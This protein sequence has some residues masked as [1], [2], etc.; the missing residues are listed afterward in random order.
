MSHRIFE[1]ALIAWAILL[2]P[3]QARAAPRQ[4]HVQMSSGELIELQ[5]P[6]A[7][8]FVAD[9]A[10]ADVQVPSG[11][12]VI[13]FGK[14]PGT[15]T[16]FALDAEGKQLAKTQII[17]SYE[18]GE[19]QNIVRQEVPNGTVNIASTPRGMVL[20]GVVP[21]A[22]AAERARAAAARYI[23][24]KEGLVNQLQISGPQ[25]VNLRVRVAE[26]SR[27]ITKQLG[28]N[29]QAVVSPGAFSFGLATGRNAFRAGGAQ[30][31][32]TDFDIDNVITRATP[33]TQGAA[34][35]GSFFGN[36]QT[37]RATVN[38]VIDALAE[39]GLITILAE[40]NLTAISGQTAS[41]LAGGEFPIPVAQSGAGNTTTITIE[42]KQFGVSLDFVPTVLSSDRISM[43]VRPE[44]SQLSTQ[45][46]IT[47]SSITIPALSVRRAETTVELGSGDSFA[48]AGLIQNT[49]T[50][51]L[52]KYP[53]L[54][55]VPIL[56]SLFRS[57]NFQ[58]NE[59]EL[60]IIVTPYVVRPAS[61]QSML[62]PTD[63]LAPA[64]D[65]E[66]I[67]LGRLNRVSGGTGTVNAIGVNGVR[68][69]GDAGFIE[70]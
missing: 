63:G 17:V 46:A 62:L 69:Q 20:S 68:L 64:S 40:P 45:G 36:L 21:D 24:D 26:V 58:R 15:T 19:L 59:T 65:I 30:L 14:K 42:F 18:V 54:G 3:N 43:R 12:S 13:V 49:T 50:S 25:Q 27:Q 66:R 1:I 22:A 2:V 7:H 52:S 5:R 67:F 23:G 57:T 56:G 60:V 55:D 6:A 8:V 61:A 35:P 41:F 28:F 9:P 70:Q 44:V 38:S 32:P 47:L 16:L 51:D 4:I 37:R 34:T 39:E 10:I 29:W 53:G 33:L 48:I 31:H 11:N